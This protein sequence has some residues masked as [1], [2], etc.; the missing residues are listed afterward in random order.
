MSRKTLAD[1]NFDPVSPFAFVMWKRLREDDF[2]LEIRPVPVLLGAL[3]NQ[4]G[5]IG[6]VEVPP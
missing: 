1:F 4:W 6:P 5:P 2:G 3:L